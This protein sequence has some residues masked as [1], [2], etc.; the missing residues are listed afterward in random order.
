VKPVVQ[1]YGELSFDTNR[2]EVR[3]RGEL[4]ELTR[5]EF[6]LMYFL[7]SQKNQVFSREALLE[8]VW[9][10]EYFGDVRTVDVTI[11]RLRSKLE[12]NAASPKYVLTKRSVGYYFGD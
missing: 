3:K 1:E 5:R 7:A 6:D 12:D 4:V 9:G 11:R 8:K 2:M 10:Y